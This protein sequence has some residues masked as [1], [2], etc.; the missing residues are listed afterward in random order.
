M[1]V[2]VTDVNDVIHR[3]TDQNDEAYSLE[4]SQ[5]PTHRDDAG[6][7]RHE[8]RENGKDGVQRHDDVLRRNHHRHGGY[9][10]R[11]ARGDVR[12]ALHLLH[13]VHPRPSCGCLK[14]IL[15]SRGCRG[16]LSLDVVFPLLPNL[17]QVIRRRVPRDSRAELNGGNF[18]SSLTGGIKIKRA[19]ERPISHRDVVGL[20]VLVDAVVKLGLGDRK[21]RHR[22]AGVGKARIRQRLAPDPGFKSRQPAIVLPVARHV[23]LCVVAKGFHP[24]LI[25]SRRD[26]EGG[27]PLEG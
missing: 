24:L 12:A 2:R 23:V 10:E 1:R 7:R 27:I 13:R 16:E 22:A 3:K 15:Q 21:R 6:D 26:V 4:E 20:G 14:P 5:S 9:A 18:H 19:T 17:L 25:R 8:N 11:R